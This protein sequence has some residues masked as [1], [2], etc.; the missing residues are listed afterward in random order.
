MCGL[1]LVL[2]GLAHGAGPIVTVSYP[3]TIM[4]QFSG[5]IYVF[6]SKGATPL[7]PRLGPV[8]RNPGPIV[9][10]TVKQ[11][12]PDTE[13]SI[14]DSGATASFGTLAGLTSGDYTF[15]AVIDRNPASPRVGDGDGNLCSSP[16]RA[17]VDGS[18]ATV[19]LECDQVIDEATVHVGRTV[20]LAEL[21][22][23]PLSNAQRR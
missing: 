17:H 20:K 8:W 14:D 21:E 2:L 3:K 1:A 10:V 22:S 4:G 11:A 5:R 18:G 7:E 12:K 16:V 15:Q 13:I 23:I 9:S 6:V 19:K